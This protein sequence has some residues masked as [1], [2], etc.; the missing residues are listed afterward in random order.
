M[1]L[2]K[3]FLFIFATLFLGHNVVYGSLS[4]VE[5]DAEIKAKVDILIEE[6][7][8]D[9]LLPDS[10]ESFEIRSLYPV[11]R[12][13]YKGKELHPFSSD[14]FDSF[15]KESDVFNPLGLFK[16]F[17]YEVY[18]EHITDF[19]YSVLNGATVVEGALTAF[20]SRDYEDILC[21][22][23]GSFSCCS[24]LEV[25]D[26]RGFSRAKFGHSVFYQC[27]KLRKVIVVNQAQKDVLF[28]RLVA[29]WAI[30]YDFLKTIHNKMPDQIIDTRTSLFN[31]KPWKI[32]WCID[33]WP[34][35][36]F[37]KSKVRQ[38]LQSGEKLYRFTDVRFNFKDA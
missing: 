23:N 11:S 15:E 32:E 33:P 35:Y 34:F 27:E 29:D 22:W 38:F 26:A 37:F 17:P 12:Q 1:Y 21:V 2:N 18:I 36:G 30:E 9:Y 14:P 6:K 16:N 7:G 25:F 24:G 19:D 10:Q 31:R 20:D 13:E 28:S 3:L 4:D 8:F 5:G